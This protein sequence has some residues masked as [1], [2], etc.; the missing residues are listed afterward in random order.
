MPI[1]WT[2]QQCADALGIKPVTWRAYVQRGHAP[3]PL[4]HVGR[5]PV[6]DAAQIV[7]WERPG[8]G[9]R[10]DLNRGRDIPWEDLPEPEE[11]EVSDANGFV[12]VAARILWNG[13]DREC[14]ISETSIGQLADGRPVVR[15]DRWDLDV[16]DLAGQP[17]R[18]TWWAFGAYRDAI[19]NFQAVTATRD[20]K[21]VEVDGTPGDGQRSHEALTARLRAESDGLRQYQEAR[22][23]ELGDADWP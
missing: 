6:F 15:L 11:I 4:R 8:P 20:P 21:I 18:V 12:P 5:T 9:A 19:A 7:T 2:N 14:A 3:Q 16:A 13:P 22:R 17:H 10:T 1:E 23:Q